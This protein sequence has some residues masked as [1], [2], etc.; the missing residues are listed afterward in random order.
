VDFV[1]FDP[2]LDGRRRALCVH[3]YRRRRA[4]LGGVVPQFASGSET[5]PH[6]I[7]AFRHAGEKVLNSRQNA[8]LS[9]GTLTL[10]FEMPSSRPSG[11]E[12]FTQQ[13][14]E[15]VIAMVGRRGG[16]LRTTN[17]VVRR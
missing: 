1:A 13:V 15:K 7:F 6:A 8:S 4:K 14:A 5:L 9:D 17:L 16:R 10:C 11:S 2:V 3:S 12:G